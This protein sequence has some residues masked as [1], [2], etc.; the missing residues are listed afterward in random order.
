MQK[1]IERL[2]EDEKFSG[3]DMSYNNP[4]LNPETDGHNDGIIAIDETMFTIGNQWFTVISLP[5]DTD[6]RY[7]AKSTD[8]R[9]V[10]YLSEYALEL[11]IE[12]TE[13]I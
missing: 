4:E 9:E 12:E 11:F 1:N 5:T 8:G 13:D 2:I 3:I 7:K 10:V 6:C